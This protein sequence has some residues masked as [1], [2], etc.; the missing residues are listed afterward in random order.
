MLQT[1]KK[2]DLYYV[3][4]DEKG[5]SR[6]K[7]GKQFIY[8]ASNGKIINNKTTLK[9]INS[10]AIPPAYENVWICSSAKGHIQATGYDDK[11]RKQY[12]YH[13]EWTVLRDGNKYEHMY[14]FGKWLPTIRKQ[15]EKELKKPGI[16]KEKLI[17]TVIKL[18][19]LTHIRIGNSQY[20]EQNNS[21]GLTTLRK[22]H[23]NVNGAEVSFD[24]R[25][26]GQ[27]PWEI[28]VKNKRLAKIIK[29]CE[30]IPGY[31]L[32]KYMDDDEEIKALRSN[33]VNM[34]LQE[35]TGESIT[36]KD[37]RTWSGT[38]LFLKLMLNETERVND[39]KHIKSLVKQVASELGNTVTICKK[40][41]IHPQLFEFCYT[42]SFQDIIARS[43]PSRKRYFSTAE[44]IL[45]KCLKYFYV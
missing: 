27:K 39:Q 14:L 11:G 33:D 23:I 1:L 32:F 6:A 10:L 15:V 25:G 41:Y 4:V 36:A 28:V 45:L 24:F 9:R 8:T 16:P 18:L 29:Q 31:E 38:V 26:K 40:C 37:F 44:S 34:Y 42:K 7:S 3:A 21:Y 22:K 13:P 12:I 17:A 19:D 30:S 2:K 43:K 35:L 5:I 20:S